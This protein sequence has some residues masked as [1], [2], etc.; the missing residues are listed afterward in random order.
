[1]IDNQKEN[2]CIIFR[3]FILNDLNNF[4]LNFHLKKKT[5]FM[6]NS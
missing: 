1:M 5:V 4:V 2:F 3:E 6:L